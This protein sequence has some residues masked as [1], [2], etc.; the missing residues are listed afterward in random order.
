VLKQG[1]EDFSGSTVEATIKSASVSTDNDTRDKHL[2]S[3]DFFNAEKY[4][5]V[6]FRSTS[7]EKTGTDT[8]TIKGDLTIRDVTKPVTLEA[9]LLGTVTDPRG[10]RVGF[11]ATTTI[12]RFDFGVKWDRT[13][14]SG[15]FVVSKD[16]EIKITS[17]MMK[18]K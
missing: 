4:P 6:T 7:F 9:K 16:V 15:G 8:Y 14:D 18:Q 5:S 12:N 10:T 3:D 13:L 1:K 11:R 2:R 17:E